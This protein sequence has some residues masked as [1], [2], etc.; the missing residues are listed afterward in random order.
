MNQQIKKLYDTLE[1]LLKHSI[2]DVGLPQKPPSKIV[3][4]CVSVL[5][6]YEKFI[7]DTPLCEHRSKVWIDD[8]WKFFC[9]IC[10]AS[11]LDSNKDCT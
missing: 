4:E 2:D 10:G 7:K 1:K 11:K 3:G 6:K 9:T 8:N 5:Y